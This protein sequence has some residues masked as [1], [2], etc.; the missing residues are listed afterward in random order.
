MAVSRI[1]PCIKMAFA[2]TI[3]AILIAASVAM[4]PMSRGFGF[5]QDATEITAVEPMHDCCLPKAKPCGQAGD[6]CGSMGTCAVKCFN[7]SSDASSPL[8]LPVTVASVI[9]LFDSIGFHS[10]T[11]NPPFRPPRV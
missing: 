3:L 2:R 8:V 9:P 11:G 6:N 1:F 4:L 7:Y 5:K 10:Q